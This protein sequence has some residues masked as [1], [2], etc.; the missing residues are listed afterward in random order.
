MA[1]RTILKTVNGVKPASG[2]GRIRG[3][4][5]ARYLVLARMVAGKETTWEELEAAGQCLPPQRESDY[6]RQVKLALKK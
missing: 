1:K 5:R 6:R 2:P 3:L 4:T